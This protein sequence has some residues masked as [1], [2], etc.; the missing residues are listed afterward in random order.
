MPQQGSECTSSRLHNGA[1]GS[2]EEMKQQ[3]VIKEYW[4]F[5][6]KGAEIVSA[7]TSS[8]RIAGY[9]ITGATKEELSQKLV[10]ADD[11]IKIVSKSGNDIMKHN[12]L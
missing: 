11:V 4:Q 10:K 9:L 12:L 7:S 2:I 1:S 8:D 5:K 3:G 6:W